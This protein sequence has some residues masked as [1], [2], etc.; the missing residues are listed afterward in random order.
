MIE[1]ILANMKLI[2]ESG[3]STDIAEFLKERNDISYYNI[4]KE[5]EE[6][7]IDIK[8]IKF[9]SDEVKV[10][11]SSI[12]VFIQYSYFTYY[13]TNTG[14]DKIHYEFVTGNDYNVGFHCKF[15]FT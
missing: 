5:N 9:N 13:Q 12:I 8:L 2:T 6:F 14:P 10:I 7:I 4:K 15:N 11:F 1:K 3:I